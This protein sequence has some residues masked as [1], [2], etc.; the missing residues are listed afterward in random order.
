MNTIKVAELFAGVGGFRLGLEGYSNPDNP[1][2][3]MPS[4][5]PFETIWANQW[6]PPG[7]DSKQFA[8]RCYEER[9]G[10]GS[11]VNED[12]NKVL[13]AYEKGDI[14]IPDVDMV[15]G[16]FPCQDY[17]VAKP[18]AKAGGIEGKK[19]VRFGLAGIKN[20][21]HN[22]IAELVEERE[23]GGDY[24]DLYDF[25]DRNAARAINK[26]G[27]E[28]LIRS[29]AFDRLPGRRSQKLH[30]FERAMDGASRQQKSV[31]A[32]QI[33]LFDMGG[34]EVKAPPPPMPELPEFDKKTMLQ[35]ERETTGVY[36]SGH[37]LDEYARE[38]AS[39]EVNSRF[40]AEL[41][42]HPDHGMEYDQ[43]VV[44]MGGLI[45]E[46][47]MKAVKSGNM[48]AFVQLEDLYGVTEV[49]VFPK[50]YERV[51]AQLQT[52]EAVVMTGKLSVREDEE[53]KLLLE[54]VAPLRGADNARPEPAYAPR[55]QAYGAQRKLYLKLR[56]DQ[57][58]EVLRIL[59]ETPG[60]IPVVLVEVDGEGKKKA[61]QAPNQYWV[62]E[63]YDFGALA[64]L[65]GADSIVLK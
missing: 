52:D 28:S 56:P 5:G 9:F 17:S 63:G 50:V 41:T 62:D 44:R 35:M 21:G 61:V 45:A 42:E 24:L 34:S 57:R 36:I 11:C 25:I 23:S 4:A 48:M 26:K 54:R 31:I 64:N 47:K 51:S 27:V 16:G 8:W 22:A 37:P 65:I 29:G 13:D 15:V 32:G 49:L 1:E 39:L 46:K 33:S 19:G 59:A 14:D 58:Q 53:A 6:E 18:L 20:L 10:E 40:L 43:R 7:N 38:L 60:R 3:D 30:V 55:R 2:F 12:I